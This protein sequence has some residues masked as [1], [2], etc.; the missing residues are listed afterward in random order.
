[1]ASCS[2]SARLAHS[3][4]HCRELCRKTGGRLELH[5]QAAHV[6]KSRQPLGTQ[7]VSYSASARN[8]GRD[9]R[10][11]AN[12]RTAAAVKLTVPTGLDQLYNPKR[13]GNPGWISPTAQSPATEVGHESQ[14]RD[15][16]GSRLG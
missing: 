5:F 13:R 14:R 1:M 6:G 12:G 15:A 10:A 2:R 9:E 7:G 11:D 8:F 16:Q 3:H 4:V